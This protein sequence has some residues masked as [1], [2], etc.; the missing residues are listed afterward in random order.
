MALLHGSHE[1]DFPLVTG[2]YATIFADSSMPSAVIRL[3]T[4]TAINASVFCESRPLAGGRD[5]AG[6]LYPESPTFA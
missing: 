5:W 2:R 3:M 4:L 1:V 6:D